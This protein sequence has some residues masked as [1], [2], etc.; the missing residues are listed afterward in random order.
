MSAQALLEEVSKLGLQIHVDGPDLVIRPA[1]RLPSE[2]KERLRQHKA[3]L[4]AA[5]RM[6]PASVGKPVECRYD[7]QP[8]YSG[9]RLRC[10]LHDH[11]KCGRVVFR[12]NWGGHDTLAEMLDLGVL[13]GQALTDARKVN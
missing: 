12:T 7:W 4:L 9:L 1:G 3:E 8:G 6:R 2:L 5:L 11:A 10:I 13:T